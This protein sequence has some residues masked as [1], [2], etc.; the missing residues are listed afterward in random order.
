MTNV[1]RDVQQILVSNDELSQMVNFT[2][3]LKGG[4][5]A[6]RLKKVLQ[7]EGLDIETLSLLRQHHKTWLQCP[8]RV[9]ESP[10]P[11]A[12]THTDPQTQVVGYFLQALRGDA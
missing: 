11:F 10:S 5:D 8:K 3:K 7:F 1:L 4:K 2:V 12:F 9:W 6:A